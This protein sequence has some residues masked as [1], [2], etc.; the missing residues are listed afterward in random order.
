MFIDDTVEEFVRDC[1][2]GD[3]TRLS[4]FRKVSRQ[5]DLTAALGFV[6][7]L[8]LQL[9]WFA[10]A[11]NLASDLV[12]Y[13]AWTLLAML[14]VALGTRFTRWTAVVIAA[15]AALA[16]LA[17]VWGSLTMLSLQN[18]AL[19]QILGIDY[20][21]TPELITTAVA[22]LFGALLYGYLAVRLIRYTNVTV[23]HA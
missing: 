23:P 7:L 2:Y 9:V 8:V 4:W 14:C 5:P 13:G 18:S 10:R 12:S 20:G 21:S 22:F 17:R 6:A 3:L 19:H 15:I 11:A 1:D 16:C